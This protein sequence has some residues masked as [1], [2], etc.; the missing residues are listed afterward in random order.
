MCS[1]HHIYGTCSDSILN[2]IMLC[3]PCHVMADGHNV[4]DSEFQQKLTDY[5][6]TIVKREHYILV[7]RDKKFLDDTNRNWNKTFKCK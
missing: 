1:L 4:S 6:A 2:S 3:H 7:D 5:T